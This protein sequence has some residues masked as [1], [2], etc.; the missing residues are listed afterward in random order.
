MSTAPATS[1]SQPEET[2]SRLRSA[3]IGMLFAVVHNTPR[4]LQIRHSPSSWTAFRIVLGFAGAAL[5]VLPLS[6]WNSW[7]A[8]IAGLVMFLAAI[9]LPPVPS[10]SIA[11]EKARELGAHAI[12]NGGRYQA[13]NARPASVQLFVGTEHI[14]ALDSHFQPLLVIPAAEI[15]SASTSRIMSRRILQVR[16]P[17]NAAEF[18]YQGI[19]AEK[20][21]RDAQSAL[22]AIMRTQRPVL[23]RS[24]A[25]SA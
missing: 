10:H 23:R 6:L 25:A 1:T 14:Y 7:F 21:A 4:L 11:E 3:A 19:F 15:S 13:R 5:V 9:L 12:V 2:Q 18:S 8:A 17:G 20:R 24:R 22:A 16:W